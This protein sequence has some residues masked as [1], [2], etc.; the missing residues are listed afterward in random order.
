[1]NGVLRFGWDGTIQELHGGWLLFFSTSNFTAWE[2]GDKRHGG[3]S[4]YENPRERSLRSLIDMK[5]AL[6][7]FARREEQHI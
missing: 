5:V 4:V 7:F 1:M 2:L 6:L 3:I